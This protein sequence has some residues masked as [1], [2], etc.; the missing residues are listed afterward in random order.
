MSDTNVIKLAQ[1][2]TFTDSKNSRAAHRASGTR[3]SSDRARRLLP[4]SAP[5]RRLSHEIGKN[6]GGC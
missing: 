3:R 1:P 2:G 4:V 5:N 6:R